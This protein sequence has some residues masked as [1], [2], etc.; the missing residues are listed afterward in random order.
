MVQQ[1]YCQVSTYRMRET[2]AGGNVGEWT[3]FEHLAKENLANN[4][5]ANRLLMMSTNLD[6]WF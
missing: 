4:R 6:A 2:L 1:N 3:R 5:S